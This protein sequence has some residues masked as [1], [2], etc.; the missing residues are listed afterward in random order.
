MGGD[1]APDA[2]LLGAFLAYKELNSNEKIVLVGD[3]D[4]AHQWFS[5]NKID[6]TLFEYIHSDQVILMN[7]HATKAIRK[8]P[9]TAFQLALRP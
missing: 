7:E 8:N 3:E 5:S 9:I 4:L 6:A 2:N 1:N